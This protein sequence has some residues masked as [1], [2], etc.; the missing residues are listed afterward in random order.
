M[1]S[2]TTHTG[3]AIPNRQACTT[4]WKSGIAKP[5][6]RSKRATRARRRCTTSSQ[7]KLRLR[8]EKLPLRASNCGGRREL[9]GLPCQQR[10]RMA[11]NRNSIALFDAREPY[12]R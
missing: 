9:P 4:L 7:R 12:Q 10:A 1:A 5:A 8:H 6:S 3:E 2:T 11:G